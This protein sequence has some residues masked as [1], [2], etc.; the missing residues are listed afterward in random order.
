MSMDV[1]REVEGGGRS[2]SKES[3]IYQDKEWD[4][5]W[6]IDLQSTSLLPD[7]LHF[8][9]TSG[10]EE[11]SGSRWMDVAGELEGGGYSIS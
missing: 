11:G 6:P 4:N 10:R 3:T 9:P 2:R 7:Q 1:K 8:Q 5:R